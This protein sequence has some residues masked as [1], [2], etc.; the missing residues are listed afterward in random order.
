MARNLRQ[1]EIGKE[2]T[3]SVVSTKRQVVVVVVRNRTT[4]LGRLHDFYMTPHSN[5]G[6]KE[7]SRVRRDYT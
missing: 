5:C 3:P 6:E 1:R 2:E 7:N 4:L